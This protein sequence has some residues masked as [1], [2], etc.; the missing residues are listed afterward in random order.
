MCCPEGQR[1]T[2]ITDI[3]DIANMVG[4]ALAQGGNTSYIHNSICEPV[5]VLWTSIRD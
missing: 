5:S 3:T 2:D 4:D 1:I